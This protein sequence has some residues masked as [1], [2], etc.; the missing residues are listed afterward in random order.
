MGR[1]YLLI[2]NAKIFRCKTEKCVLHLWHKTSF[3]K[4]FELF[5]FS[6][7]IWLWMNCLLLWMWRVLSRGKNLKIWNVYIPFFVVKSP[8]FWGP[9]NKSNQ[10]F[11]RRPKWSK[12]NASQSYFFFISTTDRPKITKIFIFVIMTLQYLNWNNCVLSQSVNF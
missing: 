3:L 10:I 9:K 11:T 6:S 4:I 8:Y 7:F 2:V 12:E 5:L 1:R